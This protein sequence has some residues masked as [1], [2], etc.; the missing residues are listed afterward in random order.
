MTAQKVTINDVGITFR[1]TMQENDAALNVSSA[2]AL[3]IYLKKP[4]GTIVENTATLYTDGSDGTIEY[5]T[6]LS[7]EL[8]QRGKWQFR[9]RVDF[10]ATEIY[11]S[12]EWESFRVTA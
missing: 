6:A 2:T 1:V 5:K 9:G 7:S 3:R 10:S 4:D 12:P 8:D 11:Y